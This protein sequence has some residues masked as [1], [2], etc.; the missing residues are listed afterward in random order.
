[1]S[2]KPDWKVS[3]LWIVQARMAAREVGNVLKGIVKVQGKPD[4]IFLQRQIVNSVIE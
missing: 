1:M 4:M 2:D 3:L